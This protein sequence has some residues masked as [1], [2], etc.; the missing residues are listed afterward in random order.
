MSQDVKMWIC[1]LAA[2][3]GGLVPVGEEALSCVS[4]SLGLY[5]FLSLSFH[6]SSLSACG[7]ILDFSSFYVKEKKKKSY[8]D[9]LFLCMCGWVCLSQLPTSIISALSRECLSEGCQN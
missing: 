6:L 7:F 2:Q 4:V 9:L 5:L 1:H 8:L 3:P